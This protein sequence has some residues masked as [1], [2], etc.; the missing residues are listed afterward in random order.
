MIDDVVC[1]SS[2]S[3][4]RPALSSK[5]FLSNFH[6]DVGKNPYRQRDG[7]SEIDV[8]LDVDVDDVVNHSDLTYGYRSTRS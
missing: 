1:D 2:N 4:Q 5:H 6:I 8:S 3:I 7:Q